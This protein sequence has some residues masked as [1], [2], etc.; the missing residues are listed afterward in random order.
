MPISEAAARAALQQLLDD[1]YALSD[2]D[3]RRMSEA[4]VV[5]QFVDR[6]LEEV[7]GWPIKDPARYKYEM[8]TQAGRPDLTLLPEK[9]GVI[10]IEAKRFGVIKELEQARF[11]E[12]GVI[13]PTQMSLPGMA[14][15]RTPEEQQ[16]INYAFANGG[17]WAI[18]TNFEKLR[19]FNARRDWLVL[20][21]ER[22]GAFLTEF[23][24]LWQLS[25]ANVL[26][27]SLDVLSNQRYARDIDSQYL[28]FINEWRLTLAHDILKQPAKNP[29][30]FHADGSINLSL[31]RTVVQR[32]LDRLVIVRF[33]ED[34]LVIP[35][36]TMRQ[37]YEMRRSNPYTYAMDEFLDRFFRRFDED[38]NSALFAPGPADE[39]VFSDDALLPLIGKLYEV[40]YRAM[41]ADILGNTYEQYLGKA[42]ALNN[43]SVTVRDN[44]ETRKKQGS[45]YTPQVIVRYI[46]D[47][48]LGRYLYGTANGQ[49]GGE[50]LP[51]ETRKTSREIQDLR[52][53]DSACGSGSFLIYA[54]K[55]LADF[56]EAEIRRRSAEYEARVQ[57]LAASF[58]SITLDDHVEAQRTQNETARINN[59]PR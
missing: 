44:L 59:Y 53:L 51:G 19:L 31:L 18:L 55:V 57:Q 39:A 1:F 45:Y 52:V 3:R 36:G 22:P 42:L 29:W 37:F 48:S 17:T 33:A 32:F 50:P 6:L 41:P 43:G 28:D 34:W 8:N 49:P 15:D 54:Y 12:M 46:V 58:E 13:T 4:S 2:D 26:D 30:A 40:R 5:R 21:F 27:G 11:T 23:D 35:P 20:S 7:L 25:Y 56:Y 38:H 16:A 9:G 10:F 24:Q 14:V 47:N